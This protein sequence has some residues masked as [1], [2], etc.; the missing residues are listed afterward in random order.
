MYLLRARIVKERP[1]AKVFI[2]KN[3]PRELLKT[4]KDNDRLKEYLPGYPSFDDEERYFLFD[5]GQ[6]TYWDTSLWLAFKDNIQ[7]LKNPV[8]AILFCSYGNESLYDPLKPTPPALNGAKVTLNR[9]HRAG[10]TPFGLLLDKP[11]FCD[12][13][14]RS[15][16][17][18][19]TDDLRD[20][21]YRFTRGHVGATVAV[22]LFLLKK[23]ANLSYLN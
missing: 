4:I 18:R 9:I 14:E 11:E 21:I 19:L 8:Y 23:G 13:I 15:S 5:E 22:S 10:S 12:V 7:S 20:F 16:K 2:H 6:T 3:W 17:L 1:N